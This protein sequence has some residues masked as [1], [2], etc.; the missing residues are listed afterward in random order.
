MDLILLDIDGTI[1]C[2]DQSAVK[3]T[4]LLEEIKKRQS[5]DLQIGIASQRPFDF[6]H[7]I[8]QSLSLRGPIIA[9]GGALFSPNSTCD[10]DRVQFF[11]KADFK[12]ALIS[13]L[14]SF[15]RDYSF[16]L[17][18]EKSALPPKH[19]FVNKNRQSNLT[20]YLCNQDHF[21]LSDL[22]SYLKQHLIDTYPELHIKLLNDNKNIKLN[23]SQTRITK[24]LAIEKFLSTTDMIHLIS[25]LEEDL[26]G[27]SDKIK[28]YSV[29]TDE[30]FNKNCLHVSKQKGS[31][32]TIEILEKIW[33]EG[34]VMEKISFDGKDYQLTWHETN[35]LPNGVIKQVSGYVFNDDGEL[36]IVKSGK[37]WTIPGGKPEGEETPNETLTREIIEEAAVDIKDTSLFGYVEVMPEEDPDDV[38]YQLRFFA[39]VDAIHD[40]TSEFETSE[41]L[42][43]P[44]E[45]VKD[46]IKWFD[47]AIFQKEFT[48]ATSFIS[49]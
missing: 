42:F 35:T 19:F 4:H 15:C 45:Q 30:T 46:Y 2:D 23:I 3:N 49:N 6:C 10:Q 25:D 38:Y 39:R 43:V 27:I 21:I 7:D 14:N 24:F 37:H 29:G 13:A 17:S 28:L 20:L 18:N 22:C 8:A 26:F 32:G 9:E 40:F 11:G 5:K 41:R 16:T 33:K 12:N 34:L 31:V 47:S 44:L 36:L 1:L 48:K